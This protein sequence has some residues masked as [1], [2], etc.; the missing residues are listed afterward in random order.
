MHLGTDWKCTRENGPTAPLT[1]RAV[2]CKAVGP[3]RQRKASWLIRKVDFPQCLQKDRAQDR[4]PV[5][6]VCHHLK[7]IHRFQQIL[8]RKCSYQALLIKSKAHSI[9]ISSCPH[10][11]KQYVLGASS[12]KI[13][14][15]FIYFSHRL[16]L[17]FFSRIPQ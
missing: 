12:S 1:V 13:Y 3:C 4:K 9:R 2:K 6:L 7:L 11:I 8:G 16:S 14:P 15:Q 10:F 5:Q 17:I